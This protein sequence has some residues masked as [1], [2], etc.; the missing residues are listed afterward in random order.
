ML[1]RLYEDYTKIILGC[2]Y[3]LILIILRLLYDYVRSIVLLP[4]LRARQELHRRDLRNLVVVIVVIIVGAHI[5]PDLIVFW[6][7]HRNNPNGRLHG[8]GRT[9]TT[10]ACG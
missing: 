4:E 3:D 6:L 9:E 10:D 1:Q 7:L 2:Y 8:N 5:L